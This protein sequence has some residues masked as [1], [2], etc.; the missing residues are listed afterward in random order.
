MPLI[1]RTRQRRQ[2][3]GHPGDG[4]HLPWSGTWSSRKR[5]LRLSWWWTPWLGIRFEPP[6]FGA[7]ALELACG[8]YVRLE[9]NGEW[10]G[11]EESALDLTV[12]KLLD[13]WG[14][15]LALPGRRALRWTTDRLW[16]P[17]PVSE[18]EQVRRVVVYLPEGPVECRVTLTRRR[19]VYRWAP[20][21]WVGRSDWYATIQP[22]TEEGI[23]VPGKGTTFYN[24]GPDAIHALSLR[25]THP[26]SAVAEVVG[27]LVTSALRDRGL[28]DW[29][30][31]P[32]GLGEE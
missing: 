14:F 9:V 26:R 31:G 27:A 25:V 4:I 18:E 15:R 11:D 17:A 23:P 22:L 20:K 32:A 3:A 8:L 21:S 6:V 2:S 12:G 5:Q 1:N 30:A 16:R 19:W 13:A 29:D 24:C 28:E 7:W 10:D